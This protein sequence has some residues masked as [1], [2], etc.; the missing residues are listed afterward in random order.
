V[1]GNFLV[2]ARKS[3][4][5]VRGIDVPTFSGDSFVAFQVREGFDWDEY[6]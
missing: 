3:G 4:L 1:H 2:V 5:L 6:K